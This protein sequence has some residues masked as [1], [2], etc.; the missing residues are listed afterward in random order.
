MEETIRRVKCLYEQKREKP[1]FWK[2]WD[3]QK[4]F[5]KEQRQKGNMPPFFRNSLHGKPSFREPR[6]TKEGAQR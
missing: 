4:R 5:K 3:G 2:A 1:T 6:M